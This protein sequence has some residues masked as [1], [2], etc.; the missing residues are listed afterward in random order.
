M[1][2]YTAALQHQQE[3]GFGLRGINPD[4]NQILESEMQVLE[5]KKDKCV[6]IFKNSSLIH[7]TISKM[8]KDEL[9]G[10]LNLDLNQLMQIMFQDKHFLNRI[11]SS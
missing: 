3:L 4:S 8:K 5:Q 2:D 7:D 1:Y 6:E 11:L 9:L 10:P